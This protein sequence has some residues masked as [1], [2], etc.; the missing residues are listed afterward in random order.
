MD[1]YYL[2]IS[3]LIFK[4]KEPVSKRSIFFKVKPPACRAYAP[5]GK[6]KIL[7]APVK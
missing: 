4:S 7:T 5:E 2:T 3:A 1:E 6:P